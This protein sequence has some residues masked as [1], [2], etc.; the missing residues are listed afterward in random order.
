MVKIVTGK[1][2]SH[3]TTR[4]EAYY[5]ENKVGDGFIAKKFMQETQ[6][7]RYDLVRLSDHLQM[8]YIV[9]E[10]LLKDEKVIYKIG[11]Y[12]FLESAF[13]FVESEVKRFIR[14]GI[15][16]VYLDEISLLEL[17]DLG[18]HSIL[19]E[20][21]AKNIDLVLVIREDLLDQVLAKYKI[22]EYQI[23]R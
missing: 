1:I 18:Y 8:P 2:N 7:L 6:V 15:S 14:E 3:K 12:C 23:L 5:Q 13:S 17:D 4:L 11:P 19:K 10:S 21:L 20:L 16:P 22:K 9:R